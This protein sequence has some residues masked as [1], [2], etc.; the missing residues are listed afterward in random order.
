MTHPDFD[1][2]VVGA[3]VAGASTAMLLARQGY[4]VLLV[5]R[6][7]LPSEIAHGHFVHRHGPRRLHNW[8]LLE[9]V[10]A[11]N[12]PPITTLVTDLG[13]FVLHASDLADDDGVPLGVGPRRAVFDKIL[14]DAAMAAGVEVRDE[15]AVDGVASD[16]G[17]VCGIRGRSARGG[18]AT[19][20]HARLT[21]GADGR[22]SGIARAVSAPM[23]EQVPTLA[24][25][26][27]S[28]F[29]GV[30]AYGLEIYRKQRRA[31]FVHPTNDDLTAVFTGTPIEEF[32]TIRSD[33]ERYFMETL[34]LAPALFERVNGGR[35]VERFYG[36]ADVPNFLRR[37]HGPGWA[38]V[39]DAGVHKD[40]LLALGCCD[41]LRDA[42]LLANA[43]NEGLSGARPLDAALADFEV[44]RNAAT[45]P[46]YYENIQAARLE[47]FPPEILAIRA[48][49]RDNPAEV[50]AF[51]LASRGLAERETFFNPDNLAR[52][53]GRAAA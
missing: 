7:R 49:I 12:C 52:V 32:P 50:R 46:D 42:E 22:H 23:Y 41:A 44:R 34:Q 48:A 4:R 16:G 31:I 45:L 6:A 18:A 10:L 19:T 14:L 51:T 38:L 43:V 39:G 26:Y 29:S 11:S 20:I 37:A 36:A 53:L 35:R 8:G 40:P 25:W 2:I 47:D 9:P 28:Y 13:D 15:F 30:P 24:C 1:A 17:R 33:P 27:F 5:D 21:I 3:R